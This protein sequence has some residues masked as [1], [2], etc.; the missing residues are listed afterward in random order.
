VLSLGLRRN[1]SANGDSTANIEAAK[2]INNKILKYFADLFFF[3][4]YF[5]T[6]LFYPQILL[7]TLSYTL[8]YKYGL[9]SLIAMCSFC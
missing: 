2:H 4:G 3:R 6:P 8:L 9:P 7:Q 5:H 1:R